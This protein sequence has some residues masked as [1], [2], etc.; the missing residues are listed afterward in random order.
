[1]NE[2]GKRRQETN[3]TVNCASESV[4]TVVNKS[5]LKFYQ[6]YL[7]KF[8]RSK[9]IKRWLSAKKTKDSANQKLNEH[10]M[11]QANQANLKCSTSYASNV[12]QVININS[13]F[14]ERYHKLQKLSLHHILSKGNWIWRKKYYWDCEK[15]LM[16][17]FFPLASFVAQTMNGNAILMM[18]SE[19]KFLVETRRKFTN[20]N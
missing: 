16:A 4:K 1:M 13:S 8:P 7:R 10:D 11:L 20:I 15:T 6:N 2:N 19:H 5:S 12:K 18:L 9:L 3:K 17:S 14:H